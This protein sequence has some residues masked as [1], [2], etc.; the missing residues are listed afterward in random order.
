MAKQMTESSTAPTHE[1]IAAR[2]YEIF[3]E[4]GR[5]QGRDLEHWLE[6]ESQLRAS[7]QANGSGPAIRTTPDNG[8]SQTAARTS[9]RPRK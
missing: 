5:P 6:A 1:Q 2:A 3:I 7:S 8:G 4:R 9:A